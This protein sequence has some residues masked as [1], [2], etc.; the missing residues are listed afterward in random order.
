LHI[1][2]QMES[3]D[4]L[5]G[6]DQETK[7]PITVTHAEIIYRRRLAVLEDAQ[8]GN[9]IETCR[10]FGISRTRYYQWKGLTDRYGLAVRWTAC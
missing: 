4:G 3:G 7:E 9:V 2:Y 1:H 6:F 10:R 5:C 8:R